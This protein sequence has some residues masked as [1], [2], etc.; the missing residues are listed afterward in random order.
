MHEEWMSGSGVE[1]VKEIC[2]VSGGDVNEG[3]KVSRVEEDIFFVV[4]EGE[5]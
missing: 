3:F 1:N 2:G 5:G 4:V